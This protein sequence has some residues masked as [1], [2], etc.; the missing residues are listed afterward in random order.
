MPSAP[1]DGPP[2]EPTEWTTH[3]SA[4]SAV[5]EYTAPD[6]LETTTPPSGPTAGRCSTYWPLTWKRHLTEPG[7]EAAALVLVSAND[8]RAQR[9]IA[10]SRFI[11]SRVAWVP[12]REHQETATA[13]CG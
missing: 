5:S 3:L 9:R 2:S 7:A 12:T 8:A 6:E 4:P 13:H 11:E 10:K 1:T